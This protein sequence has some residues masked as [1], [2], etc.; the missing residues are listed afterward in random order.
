[1]NKLEKLL[2]DNP[3]LKIEISHR[4]DI[5]QARLL[6]MQ[7]IYEGYSETSIVHAYSNLL[8][9]FEEGYPIA[10]KLMDLGE[11]LDAHGYT[12]FFTP[13][14]DDEI[15]F[16]ITGKPNDNEVHSRTG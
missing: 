3:H 13:S 7:D 15:F 4:E 11:V 14:D 8:K 1:M 6:V 16:D 10:F 5:F 9:Q 12:S 2:K